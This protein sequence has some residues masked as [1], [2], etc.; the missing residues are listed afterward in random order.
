MKQSNQK[1]IKM[2]SIITNYKPVL[3]ILHHHKLISTL[4]TTFIISMNPTPSTLFPFLRS[5]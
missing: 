5:Y 4:L 3:R 1:N 2:T